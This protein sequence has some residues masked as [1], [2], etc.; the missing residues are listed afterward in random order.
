MKR[1]KPTSNRKVI[2]AIDP[3][4]KTG[5]AVSTDNFGLLNLSRKRDESTGLSLLKFEKFLQQMFEFAGPSLVAYE[6]PGGRN[7]AGIVSHAKL[8]GE[9]EKFCEKKGIPCVGFS[10]SEIKK[11]ATGKGNSGKPEM[12]KSAQVKLNYVGEDDNIADALW[13]R[14][15]AENIYY[16]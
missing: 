9:I 1:T 13:I 5:W 11:H 14:D 4:T 12:V 3:A 7:Y 16:K 8:V 6:K 10:A 2:L 15:L